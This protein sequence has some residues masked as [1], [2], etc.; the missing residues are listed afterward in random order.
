MIDLR[1]LR[2][3]DMP[4]LEASVRKT[5]RAVIVDEGWRSGSLSAEIA[6]RLA[7]SLFY[8]LDAPVARVCSAEVPIPYP[9]HLED[10]A[11]PQRAGHRGRRSTRHGGSCRAMTE[12][13]MPTLGAD[14]EAGTL[15]EWLKQPGDAV[16]RGDIIAVVDTEKGAIEIEV[17]DDGVLDRTDGRRR[18]RRC[19]SAR[20]SR[21]FEVRA[22]AAP[23]AGAPTVGRH[24]LPPAPPSAPAAPHAQPRIARRRRHAGRPRSCTSIWRRVD[25]TGPGRH[26]DA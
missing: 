17:Y 5:R 23:A 22:G 1:T 24:R 9:K 20:C 2:P 8:E 19:R 25:G 12:F 18:A 6:A 3:L 11:L 10:A 14:M 13:R 15:V 26:G 4:T 16:K 21:A 7:E